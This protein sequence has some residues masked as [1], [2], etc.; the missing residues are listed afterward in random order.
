[1]QQLQPTGLVLFVGLL[2]TFTGQSSGQ[3]ALGE[4]Y[5]L[6]GLQSDLQMD[7]FRHVGKL[8]NDQYRRLD[9]RLKAIGSRI[10]RAERDL[11]V[12]SPPD[13]PLGGPAFPNI[14]DEGPNNIGNRPG[15][16][17][18][19]PV[20]SPPPVGQIA[21]TCDEIY[22]MGYRNDNEYVIDPDGQGLRTVPEFNVR[23]ELSRGEG[24]TIVGHNYETEPVFVSGYEQPGSFQLQIRYTNADFEQLEALTQASASCEQYIKIVC[25]GAVLFRAQLRR[26]HRDYG[27]WIARDGT[28]MMSW[29]GVPS[30]PDS[31][32]CACDLDGSCVNSHFKCNCDSNNKFWSE[33]SGFLT[34]KRYL[35]VRMVYL[36]DTGGTKEKSWLTLGELRCKGFSG[37]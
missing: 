28:R 22:R 14:P 15:N 17:P 20:P 30:S 12:D 16:I 31:G 35:P 10:R 9:R 2:A 18:D 37:E 24:V 26:G 29:G 7:T 34:D 36:G 8:M 3:P 27:W 1:M 13:E 23:C 4:I 33:D 5:R 19:K 11:G 6:N 25:M 32:Q 21:R